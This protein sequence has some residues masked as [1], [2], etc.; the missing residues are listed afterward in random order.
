MKDLRA[1][2]RILRY[3]KGTLTYG[4]RYLSQSSLTVNAF[5]D[6]DWAG[7]PDTRRSTT[8]FCIFLGSN[9][10]AWAS[11]KQPTVSRSSAEA[12]YRALATTAADITWLQHLL[13]DIGIQLDRHPLLLCDNK[14]AI[15]LSHNPVFHA[16]TKHIEIDCH[17]IREKVTVGD[18]HL[19]YLPTSKQIADILTKALPRHMFDNFRYKL[20][21]HS[22]SL[23]SLKGG[24]Q[25]NEFIS[26]N[27]G[28]DQASIQARPLED[29]KP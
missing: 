18:L 5:C 16:R 13:H 21:V 28:I 14:S 4:L 17:F 6:A 2:K 26:K 8:G 15:H 12:E 10:I 19:R 11:K 25:S 23:P 27:Q 22:H 20:G 9:C 29:I 1:V 24:K 7:C 3:I